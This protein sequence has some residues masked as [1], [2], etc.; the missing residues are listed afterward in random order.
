MSTFLISYD[1]VWP[2]NSSDYK[3]LKDY[4]ESYSSWAKPLESFYFIVSSKVIKEIRDELNNITDNNDK[5]VVL[6]VSW[7][8]WATSHVIEEVTDWMK[9]NI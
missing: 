6:D 2:E 3:K 9:N 5:I 4:I 1:L 7:D 8:N